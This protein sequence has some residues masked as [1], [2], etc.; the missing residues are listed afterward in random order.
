MAKWV[1]GVDVSDNGLALES[2]LNNGPGQHFLGTEHTLAN[3]ETAFWSSAQSDNN[4][5]EQWQEE[6]SKSSVA[7]ANETYKQMLREYQPPPLDEAIDE[8]LLA[9]IAE[10]KASFPDSDV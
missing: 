7:R 6:G 2:M 5:F 10:R 9:W 1:E 3:F 4:S 8:A